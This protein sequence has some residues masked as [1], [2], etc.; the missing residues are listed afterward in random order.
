MSSLVPPPT[1]PDPRRLEPGRYPW[2]VELQSR[3]SDMDQL[4]HLN[5]VAAARFHEEARVRFM[6]AARSAAGLDHLGGVVGAVY[7]DYLAE[8]HWPAPL[9]ARVGVAEVR[10]SATRLLQALFQSDR[11]VG[12]ADVTLVHVGRDRAGV[13]PVPD[14]WRAV[15]EGLLVD[16]S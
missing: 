15:L 7:V 8:A 12:L 6:D 2:S 10:R 11:C 1:R 5:N 4:R 13:S 14:D 9:V 16:T 3:W